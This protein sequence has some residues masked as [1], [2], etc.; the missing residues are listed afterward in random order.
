MFVPITLG[1]SRSRFFP[2]SGGIECAFF[3]TDGPYFM[4]DGH[5]VCYGVRLVKDSVS[6]VIFVND[7]HSKHVCHHEVDEPVVQDV[8]DE[9][10]LFPN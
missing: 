9:S 1:R 3:I 4:R 7:G 10:P 2:G 6:P 5:V 8:P